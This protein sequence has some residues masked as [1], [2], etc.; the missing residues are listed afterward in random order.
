MHQYIKQ[1]KEILSLNTVTKPLK[2]L[3]VTK[4]YI[5][6]LLNSYNIINKKINQIGGNDKLKVTYIDEE[7]IFEKM[8]DSESL[9]DI[10]ILYSSNE[11]NCVILTLSKELRIA[12]ITNLTATSNMKCSKTLIN[13]IGTHLIKITIALVKKYNDKFKIDKI[14]LTDHSFLFCKSI[15]YNIK[16][17]DLQILKTGETFYGKLNFLPYD[18][19]KIEQ[20]K[21]Y[22]QYKENIKIINIITIGESKLIHYLNKFQEKNLKINIDNLINFA[23]KHVS[24]KLNI[25]FIKYSTKEKFDKMCPIFNY[26]I[27]KLMKRN[28]ITSFYNKMFYYKMFYYKI[29][30]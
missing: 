20:K 22:K 16:L 3:P 11:D 14:V 7:Y 28:K 10:Y 24:D 8:E 6:S 21:L 30:K 5:I 2:G 9:I 12:T 1:I 25:F 29:H 17:G 18:E 13:N 26:I 23:N 4:K 27:P 15:K 19:D